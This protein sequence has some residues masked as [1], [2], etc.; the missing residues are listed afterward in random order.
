M[1]PGVSS[2]T[3]FWG[4][5]QALRCLRDL[6]G[7]S[8]GRE[9]GTS[10]R[11]ATGCT[12][13]KPCKCRAEAGRAPQG[14]SCTSLLPVSPSG[15]VG[16]SRPR[17]GTTPVL[18]LPGLDIGVLTRGGTQRPLDPQ[19][20]QSAAHSGAVAGEPLLVPPLPP[21]RGYHPGHSVPG[22]R[23]LPLWVSKLMLLICLADRC[24]SGDTWASQSAS[25][26]APEPLP[27]MGG[28]GG[29][30]DTMDDRSFSAAHL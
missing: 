20:F 26:G 2:R 3:C 23:G 11:K 21:P 24:L 5:D 29:S 22:R 4:H 19:C 27:A 9:A 30:T 28:P 6:S 15:T 10:G 18:P 1:P 7:G 25:R 13:T 16:A 14:G 12:P 8:C 17:H